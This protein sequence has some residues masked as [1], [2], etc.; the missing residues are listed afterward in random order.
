VTP[1][2]ALGLLRQLIEVGIVRE[3]TGR[4]SLAGV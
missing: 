2:A 3:A 1:A 4:A